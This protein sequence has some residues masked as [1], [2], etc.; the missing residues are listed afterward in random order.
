MAE[1]SLW[2]R[3]ARVYLKI[4]R[5]QLG[6]AEALLEKGF[7]EGA[8]FHCYHAFEA[9]CSA[10][11]ADR[12]EKVSLRHRAKFNQFRHLYPT[13]PFATEFASLLAELYPKRERALYA[14]IEYGEVTD[15]TLEYDADDARQIL[16]RT[17][18]LV[19]QIEELLE[20]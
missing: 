8:V 20:S 5:R 4:A 14:D 6:M 10:G 16:V 17:K 9:A 3:Q 1:T 18:G 2:K 11:I 12:S 19:A 7:Y 15:P 13:L